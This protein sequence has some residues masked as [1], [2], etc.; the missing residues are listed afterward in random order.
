LHIHHLPLL[1]YLNLSTW[2]ERMKF[3][4]IWTKFGF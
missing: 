1:W 2:K 3:G 4:Q